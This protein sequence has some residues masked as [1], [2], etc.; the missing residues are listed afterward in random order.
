MRV[1]QGGLHVF[2]YICG[3]Q[4][5]II[6]LYF[7][8]VVVVEDWVSLY[9]PGCLGNHCVDQSGLRLPEMSL[10]LSGKLGTHQFGYAN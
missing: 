7:F 8:V 6:A 3:S 10:I 2:L 4:R 9:S 5:S 1:G